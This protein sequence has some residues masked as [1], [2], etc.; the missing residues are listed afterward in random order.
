[1][2]SMVEHLLVLCCTTIGMLTSNRCC[3]CEHIISSGLCNLLPHATDVLA[4]VQFCYILPLSV[5]HLQSSNSVV[6]GAVQG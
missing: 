3:S 2:I 6:H 4:Y 1:M 5:W